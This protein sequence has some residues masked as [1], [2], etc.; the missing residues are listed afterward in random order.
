[1]IFGNINGLN[2]FD[3]SRMITNEQDPDIILTDLLIFN[4]SVKINSEKS[5]LK[6][7][8]RYTKRITLKHRQSA[9]SI[10]FATLSFI[11]SI[12]T[13]YF[14]KLQG[15]DKNWN[16]VKY[17]QAT[18]TN[19]PA[20]NYKFI[21]KTGFNDN[22]LSQKE[23]TL[24]IKV[25]APVMLS[26]PFILL[27]IILLISLCIY[28]YER[29]RKNHEN[30]IKQIN[31][32]NEKALYDSKMKLY[33]N[34]VHELR[35][36]LTLI[37][38]PLNLIMKGKGPVSDY[39][40][41]LGVIKSNS[42]RLLDLINS[43]M[44]YRKIKAG[45]ENLKIGKTDICFILLQIYNRFKISAELKNVNIYINLPD[46]NCYAMVDPEAFTKIISNLISNALKFTSSFV[47]ISLV[48]T[49][50]R[51][52]ITVED[53]G[54]GISREN[55][56]KIFEAF[57]QVKE[58]TPSDNIGSGVGLVIVKELVY[59]MNG[60]IKL[61]SSP[62]KGAKF[63]VSFQN[64]ETEEEETGL[65]SSH[66][67]KELPQ[68]PDIRNKI[69][70]ILI[71]EDNTDM[72]NYLKTLFDKDYEIITATDGR[73]AYEKLSE[74][75]TDLVISDIMMPGIDGIEL[76]KKI[77]TNIEFSH[78]PVILLTAKVDPV[79]KIEGYRNFADAYIEKP[80]DEDI[81]KT[82]V[83]SIILNREKLKE[84]F[85]KQPTSL[86]SSIASSD[87]DK[88]FLNKITSIINKNINDPSFSVDALASDLCMGRSNFYNKVKAVSGT[89]PNEL[90]KIMRLKNA[91]LLL[92]KR[93]GNINEISYMVGFSSPSYFAKCFLQ[94]FG[95][96]PSEYMKK[97]KK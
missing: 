40:S 73:T 75:K 57:Y 58:N 18:Y 82:Q 46:E 20:G 93:K 56:S 2:A 1:I 95:L 42:K 44:D 70:T 52:D 92:A 6:K 64:G 37:M 16:K 47:K 14:Y 53:N 72:R 21:V 32:E 78:I 85:I 22:D 91:A 87:A 66:I 15:F 74:R 45:G 4:R 3:P 55:Q 68:E 90:L 51:L 38:G 27:Y 61:D 7:E 24:E 11:N 59:K 50:D 63:I 13:Q 41:E 29:V 17:P 12:K 76:C 49:E 81:L 35:T 71:T 65:P 5:P 23:A 86:I 28:G 10:R 67:S 26:M 77:K 62:C 89:T 84:N 31:L 48:K 30:K 97:I 80:F 34:I 39:A 96:N 79:D 54:I 25:L 94:Q 9:F 33:T 60:T 8:I 36:P 69:Y 83:K 43:L 19:L 88:T